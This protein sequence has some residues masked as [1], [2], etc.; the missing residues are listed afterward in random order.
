METMLQEEQGESHYE[1]IE[2]KNVS[3][4]NTLPFSSFAIII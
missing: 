3:C 1:I 2:Q 4:L